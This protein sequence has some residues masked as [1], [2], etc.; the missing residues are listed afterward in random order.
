MNW[1][2]VAVNTVA[3]FLVSLLVAEA[4]RLCLGLS[5][6]RQAAGLRFERRLMP[7]IVTIAAGPA[8]LY[9]ATVS[10]MQDGVMNRLDLAAA[11]LVLLLWSAS[12]GQCLSGLARLVL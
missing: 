6:P 7:W 4:L 10:H 3:G 2:D 12:Y 9:D 5:W 8:L 1:M 11:G